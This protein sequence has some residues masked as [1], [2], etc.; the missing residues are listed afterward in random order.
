MGLK[1]FVTFS[2]KRFIAVLLCLFMT[3]FFMMPLLEQVKASGETLRVG[4][5]EA[6]Y[7]IID[8]NGRKSGYSYDYQ[9]KLSAYTGWNYE[10]VEGSWADLLQMLENGEIDM[11]A[12]V[13]YT[14]ER[15]QHMLYAS[16]PMGTESY[17]VFVSKDNN[18]I[19][20]DNYASLNGKRV[21]VAKGTV[22]G[23]LFREWA[24]THHVNVELIEL[25]TT[26]EE[27]LKMLG[28]GIDAFV[29]MDAHANPKIA[30]PLWKIGS[31]DFYFALS[32]NRSDLLP[33][34]NAAM[35]SIQDENTFFNQELNDKYLKNL[36]TSLYLSTEEKAWLSEHGTIRVG[37]QDGYMAFCAKDETTG[38]LTGAL[39]DYLDYAS[40][41]LKN[42]KLDFEAT[43]YPTASDAIKA[44]QDG[45]VDCVFP[46]NMKP[47]D[48]ETI[49]V[50]MSPALMKTEM[51]AV[52][53]EANK[54]DFA[55]QENVTVAVN[56]GNTNY[57]LFLEEHFPGWKIKYYPDTPTGLEEIAAGNA[58]CVIIS[59]YRFSNI[60]KQCEKLHLTTVYTG[61]DM[62]YYLAVRKGDTLLYSILA[63]VTDVVP[64]SMVHKSLT[65]Y[66]TEDAKTGFREFVR[67]HLGIV[68]TAVT[69]VL[70]IILV[71]LLL[72]IR[73]QK[74]VIKEH[75]MVDKL[76]KKVYVDALTNIQ[77]KR[78]FDNCMEELQ[79]RLEQNGEAAFAV[80]VFDCNDLKKINDQNGHDKGNIYLK[81]AAH[82]ICHVFQHSPVFRIG[83]D[84]FAAVLTEEDYE[85]REKLAEQFR[86][87][88]KEI[89]ASAENA[90]EEVHVAMGIAAYDPEADGT[91]N[92]TIR[93]AD[94][95]MYE[96]KRIEKE[97]AK[98]KG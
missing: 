41:A 80:G 62:D 30:V 49:G 24:D 57:E 63:K 73:S 12:N 71:L 14:E 16:L 40:Y 67:D 9:Q 59:N 87:E 65:Y 79:T 93:R 66:S 44:L 42:A 43:A 70:L 20:A 88:Q 84:E 34:L 58:D 50:V 98:K 94:K 5:H 68:M 52:V 72:N 95:I 56:E 10:F 17:Y 85:N 22:Q 29:T 25:P 45:E 33:E 89:S 38:E 82:L 55:R 60:S 31:S 86:K 39:K 35:S 7:Y 36:E 15:A 91:V 96:N 76:N 51:D 46:A 6:P 4:W 23:N 78:G 1:D 75:Q 48:A 13:S 61:V 81:T 3:V 69:A 90:W 28:N 74:K 83:G 11:M 64:D 92:D 77:N 47:Y 21:G 54:K 8:Q 97:K 2:K 27:N 19:T 32:R 37:Y 53:R 18:E 26:E